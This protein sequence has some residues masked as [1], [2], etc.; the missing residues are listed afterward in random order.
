MANYKEK[1]ISEE[2]EN[3][4]TLDEPK[5]EQ[6]KTRINP[7][8]DFIKELGESI[9]FRTFEYNPYRGKLEETVANSIITE[10]LLIQNVVNTEWTKY[11]KVLDRNEL[12]AEKDIIDVDSK[13]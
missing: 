4:I 6:K 5:K 13:D 3:D 9:S 2:K 11:Y 10:R 8:L 1:E 7:S 12:I